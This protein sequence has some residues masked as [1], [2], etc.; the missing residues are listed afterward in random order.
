M[1]LDKTLTPLNDNKKYARQELDVAP[2]VNVLVPIFGGQRFTFEA[3]IPVFQSL[4]GPQLAAAI[5]YY[6]GWQWIF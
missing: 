2:G 1:T 6:V 5:T 4:D 3:V